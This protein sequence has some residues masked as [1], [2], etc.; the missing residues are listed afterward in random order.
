MRENES[1]TKTW[2]DLGCQLG[3]V[4]GGS[5]LRTRSHGCECQ[6]LQPSRWLSLTKARLSKRG[7]VFEWRL[8]F[9]PDHLATCHES[10]S[11]LTTPRIFTPLNITSAEPSD[12]TML[13][14]RSDVLSISWQV[15]ASSLGGGRCHRHLGD[16]QRT[17]ELRMEA[18]HHRCGL[19]T[20]QE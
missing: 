15:S 3:E 11:Q 14:R 7:M 4:P 8:C 10:G 19:R 6:A 2:L 17:Y 16:G 5:A 9:G 12:D 1:D 20:S 13:A 18:Q